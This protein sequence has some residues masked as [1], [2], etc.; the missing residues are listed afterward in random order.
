MAKFRFLFLILAFSTACVGSA[1]A[2]L[3]D[4]ITKIKPSVVI[5]GSFKNTDSPRFRLR[6]TGFV[7]GNGNTVVTN[8]HVLP[9]DSEDMTGMSLVVQVRSSDRELQM[10]CLR[11]EICC[12]RSRERCK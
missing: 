3:Q 4:V 10:R 1:Q 7:V 11:S 6:G 9:S 8:A 12:I 2:D 5:V